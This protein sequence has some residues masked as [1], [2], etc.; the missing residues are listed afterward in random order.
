MVRALAAQILVSLARLPAHS[1]GD[2]S[3]NRV[4][5]TCREIGETFYDEWDLD[6]AAGHAGLSRRRF[7][8]LFRAQTS[9]S[10]GNYLIRLRLRHAAAL[11]CARE[12]SILGVIFSCGFNDVSHFYRLFRSHFGLPPKAWLAR[13]ARNSSLAG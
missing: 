4:A 8:E 10:F 9:E 2:T 6:R 5:A 13:Q 12:H 11:L 7:S 1:T 3:E